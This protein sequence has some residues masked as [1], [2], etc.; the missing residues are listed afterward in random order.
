[1]L[2][3]GRKTWKI[4]SSSPLL[5]DLAVIA[6]LKIRR[7]EGS[8]SSIDRFALGETA[9]KLIILVSRILIAM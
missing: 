7:T 3:I 1:M 5:W 2:T 9:E 6:G 4:D 8:G